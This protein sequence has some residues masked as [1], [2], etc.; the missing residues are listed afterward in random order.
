MKT[1]KK[2]GWS[3]LSALCVLLVCGT[4]TE[5]LAF[6]VQNLKPKAG[7][8]SSLPFLIVDLGGDGIELIPLEESDVYTDVDGDGLAERTAWIQSDDAF[9]GVFSHQER[10]SLSETG[11]RIIAIFTSGLDK[12]INYDTNDDTVYDVKDF[13]I[14]KEEKI[15]ELGFFI[16]KDRDINGIPETHRNELIDCDFESFSY[17]DTGGTIFC[18]ETKKY[19]VHA[20]TFEYQDSNTLWDGLCHELGST[21]GSRE[22][23]QS[24]CL[25]QGFNPGQGE[26]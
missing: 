2:R 5:I 18:Q 12:S 21:P 9:L 15:Q 26:R 8:Q 13:K 3:I 16:A 4:L 6:D 25:D 11:K 24:R 10:R 14:Y 7:V 22:E 1:L 20:V 19:T 23:Y 17:R